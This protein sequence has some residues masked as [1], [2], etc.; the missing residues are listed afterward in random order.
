MTPLWIPPFS[1]TEALTALVAAYAIWTVSAWIYNLFFHP[2][3]KFPGPRIA[4]ITDLWRAWVWLIKQDSIE[5]LFE[6]HAIHGADPST[7]PLKTAR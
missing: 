5:R 2:L 6:L 3:S 4:A 7:T 1:L